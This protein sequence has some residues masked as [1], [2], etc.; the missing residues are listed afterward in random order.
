MQIFL[1]KYEYLRSLQLYEDQDIRKIPEKK[2]VF[3]TTSCDPYDSHGG[4]VLF[5]L[6]R[7]IA[8]KYA[9]NE[10]CASLTV[11]QQQTQSLS[12]NAW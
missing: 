9:N 12:F 7:Y 3:A 10:C 11:S 6:P 1:V 2:N 4:E 8:S 5:Q